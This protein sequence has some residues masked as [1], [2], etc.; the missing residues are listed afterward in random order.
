[1]IKVF[2]RTKILL[3]IADLFVVAVGTLIEYIIYDNNISISDL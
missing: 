1:M 2:S 3:L